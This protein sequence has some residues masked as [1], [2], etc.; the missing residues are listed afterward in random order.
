MLARSHACS[1]LP[2]S[3]DDSSSEDSGMSERTTSQ[4]LMA[5]LISIMVGGNTMQEIKQESNVCTDSF[6]Q[7]LRKPGLLGDGYG[8][9]CGRTENDN[10]LS[11]L[12]APASKSPGKVPD[13]LPSLY[14]GP[15]GESTM[16]A[17][18]LLVEASRHASQG[19]SGKRK[20]S[21]EHHDHP[22]KVLKEESLGLDATELMVL[23]ILS[24][25][26]VRRCEDSPVHNPRKSSKRSNAT[27]ATSSGVASPGTST[28]TESPE[29]KHHVDYA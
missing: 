15:H 1:V 6:E 23:D 10:N 25:G 7:I 19:A 2:T 9:S 5:N 27:S 20:R 18:M 21:A 4:V 8:A 24:S 12:Q 29:R 28:P 16:P 13:A 22:S 3:S 26:W 11:T 17:A 14:A